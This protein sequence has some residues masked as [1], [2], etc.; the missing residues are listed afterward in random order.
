MDDLSIETGTERHGRQGDDSETRSLAEEPAS[1]EW[2]RRVYKYGC[3][4]PTVNKDL[5]REQ[6]YRAHRYRNLLTE[7]ER[8]RRVAVRAIIKDGTEDTPETR[9]Q[10]KPLLKA[11]DEKAVEL[12]KGGRA[13][14]DIYWGTYQLVE[15]ADERSRKTLGIFEDPRFLRWMGD[16]V[17]SVQLAGGGI[18]LKDLEDDTQVRLRD[19]VPPPGVPYN[20]QFKIL[21]LRVGS[22][23]SRQPI[24]A[25]FPVRLHR[26]LPAGSI[27]KRVSVRCE[28]ISPRTDKPHS[29]FRE[30]WEAQFVLEIPKAP[31]RC[32]H[33]VVGVDL[34]WRMMDDE[35]RVCSWSTPIDARGRRTVGELRLDAYEIG[36]FRRVETLRST[37][38]DN[39][40]LAMFLLMAQR[41][42]WGDWAPEWFRQETMHIHS[43]RAPDKLPR[44]L[45]FW[46]RQRFQG[47]ETIF[48]W[49][50]Y[51]HGRDR[52]LSKWESDQR[53][54]NHEH[55]KKK[56]EEF[57]RMLAS[58]FEI[59][60]LEDF[61]LRAFSRR[62][63]KD[64]EKLP[65]GRRET[66]QSE[67]A[68]AY[69]HMASTSE[70]RLILVNAFLT[71][72]GGECRVPAE[73]TTRICHSCGSVETFDQAA[74]IV[75]A[76][77]KCGTEW[78]QDDNAG[79]N[80]CDR[81]ELMKREKT[82][83][84]CT[85]HP[86]TDKTDGAHV[87]RSGVVKAKMESRFVR[88]K[89]LKKE[90]ETGGTS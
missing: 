90:R 17:V 16:G 86:A 42:T 71:R 87:K 77:S 66:Q 46:E 82:C 5:V 15:E 13:L 70:L 8:G 76:C 51:W 39:R 20:P 54:N 32:G 78:D 1:A 84:P 7:I 25:E 88:A 11:I 49:L 44:L 63:D 64:A 52:H 4:P 47:D 9:K 35:M 33:G 10:K 18:T 56:Y 53:R 34:G 28:R 57:G 45:R 68:R 55:R 37:R 72:G 80:L 74:V 19:A 62:P 60:V 22:G 67:K 83:D 41:A 73:N 79:T 3:R 40:N 26:P 69:R 43:W 14:C 2:D 38:D 89:K 27:I 23:E 65:D 30:T 81:Y 21:S 85:C 59:L 61:D 24:F 31:P 12:R 48:H 36:G 6:M 29:G 75:H 50:S 58:R